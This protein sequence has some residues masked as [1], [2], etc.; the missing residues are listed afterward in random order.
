MGSL[1]IMSQTA[2]GT[3]D[4]PN[5]MHSNVT[6]SESLRILNKT[7]ANAANGISHNEYA[8]RTNSRSFHGSNLSKSITGNNLEFRHKRLKFE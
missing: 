6:L 1:G 7:Q 4:I 2:S 8:V 5:R 3:R